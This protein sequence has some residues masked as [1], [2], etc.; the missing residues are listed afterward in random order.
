MR[1]RNIDGS[2]RLVCHGEVVGIDASRGMIEAAESKQEESKL[3]AD[4]DDLKIDQEFDVV[5]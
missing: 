3:S 5:F 2:D 1:R 4:S